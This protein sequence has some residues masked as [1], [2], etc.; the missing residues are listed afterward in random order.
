[1]WEG[2]CSHISPRQMGRGRNTAPGLLSVPFF[3]LC[4]H[5]S[6]SRASLWA[7]PTAFVTPWDAQ[8]RAC[9]RSF[10]EEGCLL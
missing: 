10:S 7:N 5:Q 2:E 8:I 6:D 1:M 3:L 9:T 4:P